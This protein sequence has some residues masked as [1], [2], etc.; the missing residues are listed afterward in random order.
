MPAAARPVAIAT[1][2]NATAPN[3]P[4]RTVNRKIAAGSALA[5]V[6]VGGSV[7]FWIA[8]ESKPVVVAPPAPATVAPAVSAAPALPRL[9][10][11]AILVEK[12]DRMTAAWFAPNPHILVLDFPDLVSQGEALNRVA[13][14]VEKQGLPRDRVL[15][16]QELAEAVKADN[17][18]V[19]TYY[20]GHDY[21]S[22]D[23]RR[24]YDTVDKQH[25]ALTPPEMALRALLTQQGILAPGADKAIISIPR[26]GSD[27][28]VDLSGRQSLLRH[29]L[30][31]GEYFT[32]ASYTAYVQK[33]WLTGM[34]D[35]DR[36]TFIGF[37][38]RQGYD[39]KNED[40]MAN[41]TQAHLMNTTDARY[42]NS[43]A[44]GL[45]VARLQELRIA[46]LAGMPAGWLRD[47]ATAMEPHL[48]G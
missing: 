24:F 6:L 4:A 28:F 41:E 19:G 9:S 8:H 17:S 36:Q 7:A 27:P 16:D 31:H 13:A 40:L 5:A 44:C 30:S 46:F 23:L 2:T 22:A 45:P 21:R 11:A 25:L 48:P 3:A 15:D 20:Y 12:V 33:F 29:E 39:P 37:L 10:E 42:F 14:F 43:Q 38:T 34:T 1:A 35:A 47:A 26:E 18:T 32:D